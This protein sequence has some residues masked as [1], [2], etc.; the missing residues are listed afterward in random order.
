MVEQNADSASMLIQQGAELGAEGLSVVNDN[1]EHFLESNQTGFD[2]VFLDPP[3]AEDYLQK[4]CESLLNMGNLN[5]AA[6][7]YLESDSDIAV[8]P[9]YTILKRSRAGKVQ[10]M[11]LEIDSGRVQ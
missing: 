9:P 10:F 8:K 1:A 4:C 5:P 2:I 3:F 7:L 11:L 6:L